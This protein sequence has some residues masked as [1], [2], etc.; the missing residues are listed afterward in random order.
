MSRPHRRY[1]RKDPE[2]GPGVPRIIRT[3][4]DAATGISPEVRERFNRENLCRRCG[5]C[6]HSAIRIKGRMVVLR[7]L[8]CK[9]LAYAPD[10]LAF[11]TVYKIRLLTGWCHKISVESIRK[12]LFPPDCPY[13]R[14]VTGYKGKVEL[15]SQEFESIKPALVHIFKDL[16]KPEFVRE[17]HWQRFIRDT[18][19]LGRKKAV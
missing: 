9:F 17:K 13:V 5:L 2:S 8:P 18:L 19:G 7:D 10:G 16:H 1:A 12:E 3:I 6:C 4:L 11:C 15:S 14:G